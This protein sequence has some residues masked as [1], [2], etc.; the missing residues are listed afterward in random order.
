MTMKTA[1]ISLTIVAILVS[2]LFIHAQDL[3]PAEKDTTVF[4]QVEYLKFDAGK[5]DEARKIIEEYFSVASQLAG[6]PEPLM[7]LDL[8]SEDFNYMVVWQLLDGKE[9]LNWQTCPNDEKWYKAL[10]TVAGNETKAKE[11]IEQFDS[12]V[13]DSKTEF[14][15][16]N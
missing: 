10:V 12:W 13:S 7:E 14:A 11:I 9:T 1:K 6:V 16:K 5:S 8:T 3:D 4:Y 15:R 2:G